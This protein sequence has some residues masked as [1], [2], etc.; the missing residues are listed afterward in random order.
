MSEEILS[1]ERFASLLDAYGARLERWPESEARA[2]R[3][4]LEVSERAQEM[5]AASEGLCR[6]KKGG[7][8]AGHQMRAGLYP[9]CRLRGLLTIS[10]PWNAASANGSSGLP[11]SPSLSCS[12]RTGHFW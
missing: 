9:S 10:V 2:A 7:A 1:L 3:A 5:L 8:F 6:D 4:L 11:A 12:A